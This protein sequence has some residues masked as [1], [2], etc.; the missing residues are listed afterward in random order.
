MKQ[1]GYEETDAMYSRQPFAILQCF[2]MLFYRCGL[3]Y[4]ILTNLINPIT[5]HT[6]KKLRW[7]LMCKFPQNP[8]GCQ[9]FCP[10]VLSHCKGFQNYLSRPIQRIEICSFNHFPT[11][12]VTFKILF[13]FPT[14]P[15]SSSS[16]D[17]FM[18]LLRGQK[19]LIVRRPSGRPKWSCQQ[20]FVTV[21]PQGRQARKE[22]RGYLAGEKLTCL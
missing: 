17:Y 10:A 5:L 22:G 6:E 9:Q 19:V 20:K 11:V 3:F 18:S 12:R 15:L 4:Y 1:M 8:T 2:L 14:P 16:I 21:R 13:C 7:E